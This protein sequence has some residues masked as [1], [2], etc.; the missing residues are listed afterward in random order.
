M[1]VVSTIAVQSRAPGSHLSN[2]FVAGTA[3]GFWA[4]FDAD[5][6]QADRDE[7]ATLVHLLIERQR[8]AG[9]WATYLRGRFRGGANRIQPTMYQW[10]D[11]QVGDKFRITLDVSDRTVTVGA[12]LDI[13]IAKRTRP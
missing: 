6:A 1:P 5:I 12:T 4:Y 13:T 3:G 8:G 7:P 2:E 11:I 9:P 10:F